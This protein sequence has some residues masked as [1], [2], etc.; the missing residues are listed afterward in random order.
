MNSRD[1]IKMAISHKEADRIPI[2]FGG[3]RF[4]TISAIAYSKLRKTFG[5]KKGLL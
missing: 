4:T 3:T 5:I 1:R 2:D